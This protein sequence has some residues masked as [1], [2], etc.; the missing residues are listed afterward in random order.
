M[1]D[2]YPWP[3]SA[4]TEEDMALL[5]AA[6]EASTPRVPITKLIHR[7]VITAYGLNT[8]DTHRDDGEP[9]VVLKAA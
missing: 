2:P 5:H 7:A 3:S 8:G 4:L 6:R 1:R 9:E